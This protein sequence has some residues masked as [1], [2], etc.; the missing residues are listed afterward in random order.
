V[1]YVAALLLALVAAPALAVLPGEML[2]DPALEARARTISQ[3]LRCLVCQNQ[4]IDDSAAPL[5]ADLRR[6]VRERLVAGDTDEAV[7][8]YV[9]QRYGDYVLLKPPVRE[10]TLVLW[11][12]PFAILAA[13]LAGAAVY[14]RRR[15]PAAGPAAAPL[16]ADEE[17]R[18]A[19]LVEDGKRP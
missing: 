10:D 9:T 19:A 14:L 15:R 12:G 6:L 8:R 4:P 16:S 13:A 5:A 2:A 1:R 17:K 11:Y 7:L 18:L 3:E